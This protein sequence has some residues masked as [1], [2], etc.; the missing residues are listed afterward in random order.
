MLQFIFSEILMSPAEILEQTVLT[1]LK[2]FIA[3]NYSDKLPNS[4]LIAQDFML[5]YQNY[6]RE[7]GLS[8]INSIIEDGIKKRHF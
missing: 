8:L 5:T 6:G 2:N 7:L 3:I 1:D 4:L